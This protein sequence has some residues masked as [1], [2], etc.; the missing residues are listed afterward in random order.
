MYVYMTMYVCKY[1]HRQ[2][3]GTEKIYC[4]HKNARKPEKKSKFEI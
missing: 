1:L 3:Q 2:T 4:M